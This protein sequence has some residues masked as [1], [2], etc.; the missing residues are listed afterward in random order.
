M[1]K[2]S[3]GGTEII[4]ASSEVG[5]I[6]DLFTGYSDDSEDIEMIGDLRFSGDQSRATYQFIKVHAY[7]DTVPTEFKALVQFD[8]AAKTVL[9]DDLTKWRKSNILHYGQQKKMERIN[10]LK[11]R[12]VF[13]GLRLYDKSTNAISVHSV[14]LEYDGIGGGIN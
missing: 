5:K 14:L 8:D 1:F 13:V 2:M 4:G 3:L 10:S 11:K 9:L 7:D 6:I 12:G